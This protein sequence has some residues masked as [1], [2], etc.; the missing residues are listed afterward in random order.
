MC[1]KHPLREYSIYQSI[2]GFSDKTVVSLI[3]ELGDLHRFR[4][5]NKLNAFVGIDLRFNDS[6][7]YKST[8]FITKRGNSM[9]RKILFKAVANM[10]STASYGH[11]SHINDWY[12]KKKQSS[13][14]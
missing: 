7:D 1:F 2:P 13:M 14:S 11:S 4:T 10:D 3:A 9:A 12:Q 6:D 5:D 8:G